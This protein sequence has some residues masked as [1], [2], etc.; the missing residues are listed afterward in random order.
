MRFI[1]KKRER[2]AISWL[3]CVTMVFA[4]FAG[5]FSQLDAQ[6]STAPPITVDKQVV[7]TDWVDKD[8]GIAK[9]KLTVNSTDIET[10][11]NTSLKTRIVMV[12]DYSTS[13][14]MNGSTKITELK[15]KAKA[16]VDQMLAINGDVQLAIVTFNN[17]YSVQGFANDSTT[18]KNKI[19]NTSTV[20]GTNIQSGIH[21]G[22][23][24]LDGVTADNKIMV[25]L[26][27]GEPNRSYKA[28]AARAVTPADTALNY[29]GT[30]WPSVITAFD[31][32]TTLNANYNYDFSNQT[33]SGRTINNHGFGTVSEALI[34][35]NAGTKIYSV[36][37][38]VS[39]G[40][41]ADKVLK[42][43]ATSNSMNFLASDNLTVAF[44]TIG[45]SIIEQAAG[46]GAV[47]TDPMG[48][49][50][51]VAGGNNYKFKALIDATH[52]VTHTEPAGVT[53]STAYN[54]TTDSFNWVLTTGDIKEGTYTLTYYVQIQDVNGNGV[55]DNVANVLTN[56]QA[57]LS[58]TN[59]AGTPQSIPFVDPTLK[60]EHY[61]VEYYFN[62]TLDSSKTTKQAAIAGRTPITV[63]A[64]SFAGFDFD[65]TV[66][67]NNNANTAL[68][69]V[70]DGANNII[71]IYYVAKTGSIEVTKQ[72]LKN[73][74][75]FNVSDT[76]YFGLFSGSDG[77]GLIG[78]PK[79]ITLLDQSTG[80]VNFTGLTLNTTYYVFETNSNGTPIK[81]TV[82]G[83]IHGGNY[84]LT[85]QGTAFT[86]NVEDL[87]GDVTI[88]NNV[89]VGTSVEFDGTKNLSGRYL[90]GNDVFH[91]AI[92]EGDSTT[93][94]AAGQTATVSGNSSDSID[95]MFDS[96]K[97]GIN[98]L[99]THT[100]IVKEIPPLDGVLNG[101]LFDT[102]PRTV[103]VDVSMDAQGILSATVNYPDRTGELVF[104]NEY[105][106]TGTGM[107]EV[108]KDLKGMDLA[109][110]MFSFTITE[111]NTDVAEPYSETVTNEGTSIPFAG[112]N[113]TEAGVYHYTISENIPADAINSVKD[114]ITY[115]DHLIY[116]TMTVTDNGDGTLT[117]VASYDGGQVFTNEYNAT[118]TGTIEVTKELTG[119]D[120]KDGM[121]S[122]TLANS[123]NDAK[124]MSETVTNIGAS[125]PF[126]SI[127]YTAPG[128]YQYVISENIPDDAVNGVKDGITY[129][130]HM[131]YVTMTVTD[132]GDGTLTAL[133][134]YDGGQIFTNEYTTKS[135]TWT[136]DVTK[137]LIGKD[138]KDYADGTFTFNIVPVVNT[139][140]SVAQINAPIGNIGNSIPFKSI[141]FTQPGTYTYNITEVEGTVP[142]I[143]Y[144]KNTIVVTVEVTDDGQGN[145]VAKATYDGGQVFTN[146]YSAP[147]SITV[148]K[149]VLVLTD[150][151]DLTVNYDFYAALFENQDG[152]M[153]KVSDV[154]LL[155]IVD[156]ADVTATFDGLDLDKTYQVFE[157]DADGNIIQTAA[158]GTI[159]TPIIPDWTNISYDN[160]TVT[161]TTNNTEGTSTI[162]NVFN[163]QDF[164]LQGSI[165]VKKT[166]T[167]NGKPFASNRTFYVALFADKAMT[168]M[169][170]DVKALKMNGNTSTT[171]EFLTDIDG[172]P[173]EAGTTYYIAETDKNGVPLTG[174]VE[175][176]GFE[177][178]IDTPAVVITEEGTTVN[179]INKFKSEEF[180]L[181]GDNSNMSLW[182]FLAMLGVAGAI[183]PF[184]FRKKEK[185][186]D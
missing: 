38:D 32:N 17:S 186:N 50:T 154:K 93:P 44:N 126:D 41:T 31:Y 52:P 141:E 81:D 158:D 89:V 124:T 80:S 13:M 108:T 156:S 71:K 138:I 115:D 122:F 19:T 117:A 30:Q 139:E 7:G 184:A 5:P 146:T 20:D 85:G 175:K 53:S 86:P 114:G 28:T 95:I 100:Y 87:S 16:F 169:I 26:S 134:S 101:I 76:F 177:I 54:S 111:T 91:F 148:T 51:D 33:V 48:F 36:G 39:A 6:A 47:V 58:Y 130:D 65:K 166:V 14:S 78:T 3:V 121:F 25:V 77:T 92:F 163:P 74:V 127:E 66:Y 135:A 162:T 182:L 120:L 102:L 62:G 137:V 150:N 165:T 129:D 185:V 152:T 37:F 110:D 4:S 18:L 160:Q 1:T 151:P 72:V 167:V 83:F 43:V 116:V 63:V 145:L 98:D 179:I 2:I 22:Q 88:K 29:N 161:L 70:Q 131:I 67:G 61:T 96:I 106:A 133:A 35:K 173:L 174:T 180:P 75:A 159:V 176:L 45:T 94:I 109:D 34:A 147:G 142:G 155:K 68:N 123:E 105:S 9:V 55:G 171:T 153:V 107:V 73:N 125:I 60:V 128:V 118:G 24:L 21:Q 168:E 23:A 172:N 104:D 136:P 11:I 144:D 56:H 183:A 64:P 113:Y 103:T 132:N 42:S 84:V 59:S 12:L 149:K 90:T 97:Y 57:V 178:S 170:S 49:N 140:T 69:I 82:G 157:T 46:T 15:N 8:L 99:G 112:I 164:P 181:T 143:T 10:Q 40:S 119:K 79:S 27:D